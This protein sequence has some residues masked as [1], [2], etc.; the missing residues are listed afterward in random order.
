[1]LDR[2]HQKRLTIIRETDTHTRRA[3]A[4]WQEADAGYTACAFKLPGH[5]V[6]PPVKS[7]PSIGLITHVIQSMVML[8]AFPWRSDAARAPGRELYSTF[9]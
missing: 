2:Q 4:E 7:R 6:T 5:Y 1:M 3:L 8:K 9:N